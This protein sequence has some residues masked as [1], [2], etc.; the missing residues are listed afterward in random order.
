VPRA[1]LPEGIEILIGIWYNREMNYD[2]GRVKEDVPKA[3]DF[4]L[5]DFG[6]FEGL[7]LLGHGAFATVREYESVAIRGE[8]SFRNK[9]M[10]EKD[11]E[12]TEQMIVLGQRG[13]EEGINFAPVL[14]YAIE[15]GGPTGNGKRPYEFAPKIVG[16]LLRDEDAIERLLK[17][18][19]GGLKKYFCDWTLLRKIGFEID[20]YSFLNV[21]V[22]DKN[23]SFVDLDVCVRGF[24]DSDNEVEMYD[25]TGSILNHLQSKVVRQKRYIERYKRQ[26][27]KCQDELDVFGEMQEKFAEVKRATFSALCEVPR[28]EKALLL[29]D[30]YINSDYFVDKICLSS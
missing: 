29:A 7:G 30:K 28:N 3:K 17:V 16:S 1:I 20:S 6:R 12:R 2:L 13:V 19:K 18:G 23:I 24:R 27:I 11:K 10:M 14:D 21:I 5:A 25:A 15:K 22:G 26:G 4:L 8:H 9:A